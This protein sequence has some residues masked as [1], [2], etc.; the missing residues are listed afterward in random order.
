VSPGTYHDFHCTWVPEIKTRLNNGI[1]PPNCDARVEQVAGDTSADVPTLQAEPPAPDESDGGTAPAL[2]P[3]RVR[4][5]AT[6]DADLYAARARARAVVIRHASD[7]RV[8][9]LIEVLSPGNKASRHAFATFLAKAASALAH[10]YHLLLIDLFPPT[11]RDPAGLH[12][13]PWSELGGEPDPPP[14]DAPL[15]L[16]AYRAGMPVTAYVEPTAVG[17]ALTPMP[18]F[19]SGDRYVPVPLEEAYRAAFAGVPHR[20]R[21]V[22]EP[23]AAD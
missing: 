23:D 3:P 10:G 7:D 16:A 4:F 2:A 22:L 18:L 20:W 21:R 12:A 15:T 8:I 13:A 1:L 9:A 19:L 17:A 6:L 11:P 14:A 5:T